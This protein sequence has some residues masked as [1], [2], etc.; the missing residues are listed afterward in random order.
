VFDMDGTLNDGKYYV[1]KDGNIKKA[2]HVGDIV[3]AQLFK[4]AGWRCI[5]I[6]SAHQEDSLKINKMWAEKRLKVEF[7]QAK[8]YKKLEVLQRLGIDLQNTYYVGDC[9]DDLLVAVKCKY[10]FCPRNA[11]KF[12]RDNVDYVLERGSGEGILLELVELL[13][14]FE[15][16]I[17][18]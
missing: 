5:A 18:K 8:L 11:I 12:V 10:S 17:K 15:I 13:H 14:E 7:Y 3:G 16:D 4:E 9:I 1:D 2:F 6:T